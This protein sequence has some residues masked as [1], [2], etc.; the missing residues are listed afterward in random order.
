VEHLVWKTSEF[1]VRLFA[2]DYV[3]LG[4]RW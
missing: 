2:E 1:L 4:V 3:K